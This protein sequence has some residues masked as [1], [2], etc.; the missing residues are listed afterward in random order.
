MNIAVSGGSGFIGSHLSAY[1]RQTGNRIITIS[2]RLESSHKENRIGLTWEEL[3]KKRGMLEGLDGWIHLSGETI[4]QR[5]TKAAKQ[6]ILSSRVETTA[7]VEKTIALL[8]NKPKAVICGSAIG[9]YGTS[10]TETYDENSPIQ[11]EDFLCEV[12][13]R[14]EHAADAIRDVRL[15][16]LRTGVVLGK[17]GGAFPKMILPYKWGLGGKI[18]SGRQWLSWIHIEDMVKAID[19]CLR[20]EQISGPVNAVAPNPV[21]NDRFGRAVGKKLHRPH[22]FPVPAFLIK[23]T[24]GEM[25]DLLLKG[26]KVLPQKL[27]N[28]GFAFQYSTIEAALNN[29]TD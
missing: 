5:W 15:V 12:V 20:N 9:I 6:T 29:L 3:D 13:T 19:F 21:T 4:N 22:L 16:K 11:A 14:W 8:Q 24:F 10:E 25:S 28:H 18:G 27:T 1:L 7:R 23:A 26:Q 17:N 2:R